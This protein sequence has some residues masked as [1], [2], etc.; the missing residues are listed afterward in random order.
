MIKHWNFLELL[1]K[2]LYIVLGGV[3]PSGIAA[4]WLMLPEYQYLELKSGITVWARSRSREV[5]RTLFG[6]I[7]VIYNVINSRIH[8]GKE[9]PQ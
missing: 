4:Y 8:V 3:R 5:S 6:L 1:N 9:N 7:L 2:A